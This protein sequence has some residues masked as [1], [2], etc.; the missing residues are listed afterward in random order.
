M[1]AARIVTT[2]HRDL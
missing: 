1:K 2:A